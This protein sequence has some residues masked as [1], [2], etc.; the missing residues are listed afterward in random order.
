M[1]TTSDRRPATAAPAGF[2]LIELLVVI[3][4][5]GILAGMLLPVLSRAKVKAQVSR[6]KMEESQIV[7]A[8]LKYESAYSQMPVSSN[9]MFY[10][11]RSGQED[12][13]FGTHTIASFPGF[14]TPAGT[15]LHISSPRYD[16]AKPWYQTNNSEVI[17]ILLDLEK[18]VNDPTKTPSDG[19]TIN[20][21][22]LKNPQREKFLNANLTSDIKLAGIGPDLVYRDPWGQPYIISMDLNFDDKTRDAFYRYSKVSQKSGT[23]GHDGL[24]NSQPQ[25]DYF[26]ANAK[27]MVWSAGPDKMIDPNSKANAG[28]NKDN[29]CSWRQ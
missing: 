3:S 18:Y 1:K 16:V 21:N 9:A 4:I 24:F 26:E 20:L 19:P 10:A 23:S 2:T 12:F 28:A 27:V 25:G 14:K 29:V 22:H 13:T 6:A 17:A 7:Q 15:T 8:V 11:T 5:I